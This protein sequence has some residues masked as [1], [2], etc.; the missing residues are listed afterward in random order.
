MP[1]VADRHR[2]NYVESN[3]PDFVEWAVAALHAERAPIVRIHTSGDFYSLTYL[4]KWY[5]II[6][7]VPR[8]TFFLYTRCWRDPMYRPLL[9][10]LTKLPNVQVWLSC[11]VDTGRPPAIPKTRV[12]WMART[13]LEEEYTPAWADLAFRAEATTLPPRKKLNGVQVCPH[14]V[15]TPDV[16]KLSCSQCKICCSPARRPSNNRSASLLPVL[17]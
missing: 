12:A 1:S 11:D 5:E 16:K 15:G 10:R 2:L 7:A 3:R 14:E 4:Q 8:T 9:R 17:Q 13:A 6:R